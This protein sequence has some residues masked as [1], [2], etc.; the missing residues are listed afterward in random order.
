MNL[1]E[2]RLWDEL[3][4]QK[5]YK[6]LIA[7]ETLD[8]IFEEFP[9]EDNYG[10]L[11]AIKKFKEIYNRIITPKI[12][13]PFCSCCG[14]DTFII[15]K[16]ADGKEMAHDCICYLKA[17]LPPRTGKFSDHGFTECDS[18]DCPNPGQKEKIIVSKNSYSH[19]KKALSTCRYVKTI[20]E[21]VEE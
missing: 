15:F 17:G 11:P 1:Y 20:T 9:P 4:K 16:H 10:K 14:G 12:K 13:Q 18:L 2:M 8:K 21:E 19:H 3:L 7:R 5:K 6:Y